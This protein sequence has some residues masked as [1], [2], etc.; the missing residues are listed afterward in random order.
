MILKT[1]ELGR[2]SSFAIARPLSLRA[3]NRAT[4]SRCSLTVSGRPSLIPLRLAC[5]NPSW[6]QFGCRRTFE[7]LD[8]VERIE[9]HF[10]RHLGSIDAAGRNDQGNFVRDKVPK[11]PHKLIKTAAKP[12]QTGGQHN[13]D[14]TGANQPKGASKSVRT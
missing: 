4:A 7:L 1:L 10:A 5:A 8:R 3:L 13:L 12:A 14:F 2:P 6:I 9:K 11:H